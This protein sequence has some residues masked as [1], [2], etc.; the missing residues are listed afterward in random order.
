MRLTDTRRPSTMSLYLSSGCVLHEVVHVSR[1][2]ATAID[3]PVILRRRRR[4]AFARLQP[5]AVQSSFVR[6][7]FIDAF[8]SNNGHVC[9]AW[10][11]DIF[12]YWSFTSLRQRLRGDSQLSGGKH[13]ASLLRWCLSSVQRDVDLCHNECDLCSDMRLQR[14]RLCWIDGSGPGRSNAW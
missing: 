14:I 11:S 6:V 2:S 3:Q 7:P 8:G 5:V 1:R 9:I 10:T 4:T 13:R 12:E